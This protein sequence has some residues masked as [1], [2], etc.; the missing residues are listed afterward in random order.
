MERRVRLLA[1]VLCGVAACGVAFLTFSSVEGEAQA[2]RAEALAAYGGDVVPVCVATREIEAG[3][4]LDA[5]CVEVR[6]WAV[7]LLP[8]DALTSLD[9]ARG[10]EVSARVPKGAVIAEAYFSAERGVLEVPD[11]TVAVS[12]PLQPA[13]ALGGAFAPGEDVD[14][15]VTS[16]GVVS[17]LAEGCRVVDANTFG[18][19][20]SGS[21]EWA[22]LAVAPEAAGELL[23]ASARGTV[24]LAVPGDEASGSAGEKGNDE[25]GGGGADPA[26]PAAGTGEGQ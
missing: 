13:Y 6:D 11:G 9:E 1:S 3:E 2:A 17:R 15:Y 10:R 20:G 7:D 5:S 18:T 22:T 25:A 16:D 19:D 4:E 24:A 26:A 21:L 8:E 14:V 23:A 12:V